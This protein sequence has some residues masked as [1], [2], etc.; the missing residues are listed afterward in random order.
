[1]VYSKEF[2]EQIIIEL[3]Q[4]EL[5]L[6]QIADKFN[7]GI[8]LVKKLKKENNIIRKNSKSKSGYV[9]NSKYT[10]EQILEIIDLL[11]KQEKVK[12]ISEKTNVSVNTI[13]KI[14]NKTIWTELTKDIDFNKTYDFICINCGNSFTT[15]NPNAKYCSHNCNNQYNY[16]LHTYNVKCEYCN[17]LFIT[18]CKNARFCS[19]QCGTNY[20][21][22]NN[23]IS[24]TKN[25]T[26][27]KS[28][29]GKRIDLNNQYFRSN[30]EANIARILKSKNIKYEYEKHKIELKTIG[31]FYIPD[32]YLPKYKLYI[33]VKGYWWEEGEIKFN[34]FKKETPNEKIML[35]DTPR[36]YKIRKK[37]KNIIPY[38]EGK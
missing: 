8:T 33:E 16:K 9:N 26:Y 24:Q 4:D 15:T 12:D 1:M 32:F 20:W 21:I 13:N 22:L 19:K 6:Q 29:K 5:T 25:G 23:D 31:K 30:W 10:K 2:K 3:K 14:R 38:W 7:V 34:T 28:K 17:K 27:K 18:H 35:I 11:V 36:Y 37:Y